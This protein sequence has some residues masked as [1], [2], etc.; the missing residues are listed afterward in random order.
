M[1]FVRRLRVREAVNAKVARDNQDRKSARAA[2]I[3]AG[4][5]TP[6]GDLSPAYGGPEPK[7]QNDRLR[8][9]ECRI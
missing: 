2:L 9:T 6:N 5:L 3:R 1:T 4:Y 8:H 7:K